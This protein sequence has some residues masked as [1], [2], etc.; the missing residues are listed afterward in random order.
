MS[1][2]NVENDPSSISIGS[3]RRPRRTRNVRIRNRDKK[4][5]N[6]KND[7][8]DN[9]TTSNLKSQETEKAEQG[10]ADIKHEKPS[11]ENQI[12]LENENDTI[13]QDLKSKTISENKKADIRQEK[14]SKENQISLENDAI[15]QD[16]EN[17]TIKEESLEQKKLDK[18]KKRRERHRKRRELRGADREPRKRRR[19]NSLASAV[20]K[21]KAQ[22]EDADN[23]KELQKTIDKNLSDDDISKHNQVETTLKPED[24]VD[25]QHDLK[26]TKSNQK[27]KDRFK[28]A[29]QNAK[30]LTEP[31]SDKKESSIP[32]KSHLKGQNFIDFFKIQERLSSKITEYLETMGLKNAD[33]NFKKLAEKMQESMRFII[34]ATSP[35]Y[36][37]IVETLIQRK[38]LP[39]RSGKNQV[40][41]TQ[42]NKSAEMVVG[43]LF[44]RFSIST[45]YYHNNDISLNNFRDTSKFQDD[46]RNK[47]LETILHNSHNFTD[48]PKIEQPYFNKGNIPTETKDNNTLEDIPTLKDNLTL[49]NI[50][51]K[52]SLKETK[53]T[54]QDYDK[55][56]PKT[57]TTKNLN[58]QNTAPHKETSKKDF[59]VNIAKNLLK[60]KINTTNNKKTESTNISQEA[61]KQKLSSIAQKANLSRLKAQLKNR[62]NQNTSNK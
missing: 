32:N 2:K 59:D 17:E 37:K 50:V 44:S 21:L 41:N 33:I 47:L 1:S 48:I 24:I 25:Q 57:H 36:K 7:V 8:N 3:V 4:T 23:L 9:Q 58:K 20:S 19:L 29:L 60:D 40:L 61:K 27:I 28:R 45:P 12:S 31:S 11:K 22:G 6:E 51:N 53:Q 13:N 15:N 55:I 5:V 34:G 52:N 16:V 30:M 38:N 62:L 10:N 49:S 35:K 54:H 43:N 18:R 14:F 39:V 56:L 26:N 42:A 46:N